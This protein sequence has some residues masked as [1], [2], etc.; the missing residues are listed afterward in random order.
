MPMLLGRSGVY[1]FHIQLIRHRR[2][3]HCLLELLA[4]SAELDNL[5]SPS[6]HSLTARAVS[7]SEAAALPNRWVLEKNCP[8]N[9]CIFIK[10]L[11][12]EKRL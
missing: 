3:N 12:L 4:F 11:F 1:M 6:S 8:Y 7:S 2:E 9:Y 5:P 10:E